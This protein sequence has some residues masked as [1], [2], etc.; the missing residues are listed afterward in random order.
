MYTYCLDDDLSI[1]LQVELD[2]YSKSAILHELTHI[3]DFVYEISYGA[4]LQTLY[5]SQMNCLKTVSLDV[6]NYIDSL[7]HMY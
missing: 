4:S 7:Y 2:D 5:Q 3:Y 1:V 6:Y